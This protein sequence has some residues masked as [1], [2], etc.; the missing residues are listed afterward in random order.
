MAG[1]RD[2]KVKAKAKG[3]GNYRDKGEKPQTL[4]HKHLR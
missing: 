3:K 1:G 4:Q 2:S